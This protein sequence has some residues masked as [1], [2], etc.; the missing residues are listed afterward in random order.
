MDD[1][2]IFGEVIEVRGVQIALRECEHCD[3]VPT[4]DDAE[5]ALDRLVS[6]NRYTCPVCGEMMMPTKGVLHHHRDTGRGGREK[7][8]WHLSTMFDDVK[9]PSVHITGA[10]KFSK[11]S[12]DRP[13]HKECLTRVFPYW[14]EKKE[15]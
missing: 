6:Q 14:Y 7:E 1:L 10:E 15:E 8:F 5:A 11:L 2:T 12:D 3:K 13:A 9:R 4:K